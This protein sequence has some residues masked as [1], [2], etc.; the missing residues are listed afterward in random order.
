[1]TLND[2]LTLL[3]HTATRPLI[4]ADRIPFIMLGLRRVASTAV[5]GYATT[6]SRAA[7]LGVEAMASQV[8]LNGYVRARSLAPRPLHHPS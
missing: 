8:D 1:M 6:T 7:K 3:T 4:A 5:R 2:A